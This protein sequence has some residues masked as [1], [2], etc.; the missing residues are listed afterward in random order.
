MMMSGDEM[1]RA[2]LGPLV[3][4]AL[5]GGGATIAIRIQQASVQA[6]LTNLARRVDDL[7]KRFDRVEE[8][9][10]ALREQNARHAERL[11]IR[12]REGGS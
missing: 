1:L 5:A 2:V 3:A 4:A 11:G 9:V 8:S 12:N 6:E 10:G 7:G